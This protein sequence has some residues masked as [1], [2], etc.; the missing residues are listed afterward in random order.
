MELTTILMMLLK[1]F[2]KKVEIIQEI[3]IIPAKPQAMAIPITL[4]ELPE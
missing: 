4:I 1:N 3:Q 2:K